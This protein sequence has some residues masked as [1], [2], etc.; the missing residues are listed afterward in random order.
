MI[1]AHYGEFAA[2]LVAI[3]WTITAL[4]FESATKKVG[5]IAVNIIRLVIGFLFLSTLTLILRGKFLPVDA[6]MHNWIWLGVSGLIGFVIGDLFLFKSYPIVGSWFSMLMM[7]LAPP[8]AAIFGFI[9]LGERMELKSLLGMSLTITGIGLTIFSRKSKNEKFSLNKPA[10]GI[11]YA[12]IG[13]FGQGLGIVFS[14]LGMADYDPFAS[15]QIRII[16]G[17]IG[18]GI[19]ISFAGRWKSIYTALKNRKGMLGITVG[20]FFGPFLG[21]SFSL[22]A[23]KYTQTGIAS[24]IMAIVPILII[25]PSILFFKHKITLREMIGAI[26]GV[27][28][29]MLFFV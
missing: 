25:P 9:I 17:M 4:A 27:I 5:S 23:I 2:L 11:L 16:T 10:I 22:V 15:T 8:I 3:F 28:G 21:V 24:T 26:M 7:T 19:I 29:V 12:L 20:S 1:S 18:F 6:S 14:K 13:A